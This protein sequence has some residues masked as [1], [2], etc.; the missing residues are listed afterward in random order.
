MEILQ[1]TIA[2]IVTIVI[3][4]SFHEFGHFIVAK[5]CNVK[6]LRFSIGFGRPIF[7][8]HFGRDRTEFVIAPIPLGGY[9]KMLDERDGQ[10]PEEGKYLAFNNKPIGQRM[11]IVLAGP[12]FNF[13]LA[14][15]VYWLVLMIGISGYKPLISEVVPNS[16]AF[17]HGLVMGEQIV[18]VN[19]I[20]TPTQSAVKRIVVESIIENEQVVLTLHSQDYL[21]HDVQI[22][23]A[24]ISMDELSKGRLLEKLGIKFNIPIPA[25]IGE[26]IP[27]GAAAQAGLLADDLII[28]VDSRSIS[29][30]YSWVKILQASSNIPLLHQVRRGNQL[31]EI[32]VTPEALSDEAGY[33]VGKIGVALARP[34]PSD[35]DSSLL[36]KEYYPASQAFTKAII[37]TYDSSLL[38][39][40]LLWKIL[41]GQ[42]SA[43][44]L[45]GPISIAQYAGYSSASGGVEFLLFLAIISVSLGVLNLLPIPLLDGGHFLYYVMELV[46]GKPLP[47]QVQELGFMIG[48]MVLFG[49]MALV[50][51]NDIMR[52][53]G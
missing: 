35:I 7:M 52:L 11:V 36:A 6:I 40:Q 15:A 49:L 26:V 43:K 42:A 47:A 50:F 14:I 1:S 31:L 30:W 19:G 27:N 9:V 41:S 51:Y 33:T 24:E 29:D 25:R 5:F 23:I 8:R 21:S 17:K 16:I 53:I 45:N 32:E 46:F 3:V 39:L 37:R 13:I 38:T 22:D 44:L 4:V 10:V 18:A 48:G 2:F 12:L 28:A 20:E 34:N